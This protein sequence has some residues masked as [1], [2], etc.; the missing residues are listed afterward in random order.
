MQWTLWRPNKANY[1]IRLTEYVTK[2]KGYKS[3]KHDEF[4]GNAN[5]SF[6]ALCFL[7]GCSKVTFLMKDLANAYARDHDDYPK[8]LNGY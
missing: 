8:T 2:T 5:D 7:E 4:T 3:S 6:I 1:R